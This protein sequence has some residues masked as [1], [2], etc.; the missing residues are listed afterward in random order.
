MTCHIQHGAT[1]PVRPDP[2][3]GFSATQLELDVIRSL[4]EQEKIG[5]IRLS[6]R[7]QAIPARND[8]EKEVIGYMHANCA[9]C[10]RPNGN[11]E[12]IDYRFATPL[13]SW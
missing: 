13:A 8:L 12:S 7:A 3:L 6:Q 10:H 4:R 2:V 5:A 9:I 1:S 11:F